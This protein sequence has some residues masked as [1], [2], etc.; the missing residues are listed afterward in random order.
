MGI[1]YIYCLIFQTLNME[2]VFS[3]E[4]LV[5]N[6]QTTWCHNPENDNINLQSREKIKSYDRIYPAWIIVPMYRSRT[7]SLQ[8]RII[9][10]QDF[11]ENNN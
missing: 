1:L 11:L 3:S 9:L 5:S 7:F 2:A 8:V 10:Q 6:Y 4:K